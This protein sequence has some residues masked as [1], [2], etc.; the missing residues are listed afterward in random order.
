MMLRH[1]IRVFYYKITN[2]ILKIHENI[3]NDQKLYDLFKKIFDLPFELL[4]NEITGFNF[5][6]KYKV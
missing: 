5:I 2:C 1:L 3:S 4:Y 6:E